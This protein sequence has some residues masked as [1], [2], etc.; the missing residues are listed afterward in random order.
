MQVR[1]EQ[2]QGEYRFL[3]NFWPA[4]VTLDGKFYPSVEHAYQA[5]K[6]LDPA[7]RSMLA[8][9][10][11]G[12][13]KQFGKT[14]RLRP[15]WGEVR[16]GI[17][18]GLIRQKFFREPLRSK[19]LATLELE[20]IEGNYWH[21]TFWGVCRGVGHN[22]LGKI[23]MKIRKELQDADASASSGLGINSEGS[24]A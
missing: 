9:G 17:M 3:S 5:A 8:A 6:T 1:I 24:S 10:S 21:D 12:D 15:D 14:V 4:Q 11:A 2:F 23:I 16:L 22:H 13:A 18:E 19:L 20:L 7:E